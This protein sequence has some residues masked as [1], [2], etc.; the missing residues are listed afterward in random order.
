VLTLY[1]YPSEFLLNQIG[2]IFYIV[3]NEVQIM[4]VIVTT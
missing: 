1:R 2:S 3:T 4:Y